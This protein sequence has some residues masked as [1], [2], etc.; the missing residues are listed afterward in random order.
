MWV[1]MWFLESWFVMFLYVG[2]SFLKHMMSYL[3]NGESRFLQTFVPIFFLLSN[4]HS[5]PRAFSFRGFLDHTQRR[6]TFGRTPLDE[7]SAP[8]KDLYLTTHSTSN[9]QISTSPPGFLPTILTGERTHTYALDRAATATLVPIYYTKKTSHATGSQLPFIIVV[10][11]I[12]K[13]SERSQSI[14]IPT[15]LQNRI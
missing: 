4:S 15:V 6:T 12:I 10:I 2:P 11:N 8:H 14:I 13:T 5:W 3:D 1:D 7:W 9:R